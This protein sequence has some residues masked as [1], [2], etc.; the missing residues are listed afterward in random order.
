[1]YL[2]P[3]PD[4]VIREAL[5]QRL[6]SQPPQDA[7]ADSELARRYE[8]IIRLHEKA[9]VRCQTA[10]QD[11]VRIVKLTLGGAFF[12]YDAAL[13]REGCLFAGLLIAGEGGQSADVEA[14]LVPGVCANALEKCR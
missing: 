13:V 4:N 3:P 7:G 9:R 12:A 6:V 8:R 11:V 1:M 2:T 5:K 10:V 14:C